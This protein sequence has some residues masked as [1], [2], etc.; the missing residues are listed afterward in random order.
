LRKAILVS[1]PKKSKKK[2]DVGKFD[3]TNLKQLNSAELMKLSF[4]LK[5]RT[6]EERTLLDKIDTEIKRR[7]R[8]RMRSRKPDSVPIPPGKYFVKNS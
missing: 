1:K 8:Q 3:S 2:I 6:P 7:E 5:S 4:S